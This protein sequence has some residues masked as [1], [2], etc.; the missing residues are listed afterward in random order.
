M[1]KCIRVCI[2]PVRCTLDLI[3]G[4]SIYFETEIRIYVRVSFLVI[5][6]VKELCMQICIFL[7]TYSH[8]M[9]YWNDMRI[10]ALICNWL[11]FQMIAILKWSSFS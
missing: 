3:E 2:F 10:G 7:Y 8:W 11:V 4:L 5:N 1:G 9:Q 6:F